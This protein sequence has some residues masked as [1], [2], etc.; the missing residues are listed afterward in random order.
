MTLF[1]V[2]LG[3]FLATLTVYSI[4]VA[5]N[6]GINLFIPF[7]D[8]IA[9]MNWPGQFNL[10]FMGFLALSAI[11]VAWRNHFTPTALALSVLAFFG[12]MI[13]LPIYLFVLLAATRGCMVTTLVGNNRAED[14]QHSDNSQ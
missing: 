11:W 5:A 1:R 8:A 14:R 7:F 10:D 4:L 9:T 13:F 2:F 6:H 3:V 12:G